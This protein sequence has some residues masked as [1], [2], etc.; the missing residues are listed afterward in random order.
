MD[1]LLRGDHAVAR[2]SVR[3]QTRARG[4]L[5]PVPRRKRTRPPAAKRALPEPKE[6]GRRL[7]SRLPSRVQSPARAP[8]TACGAL[9]SR[10]VLQPLVGFGVAAGE[11]AGAAVD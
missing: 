1:V 4:A 8:T 9:R 7:E 10:D 11:G 5:F 6:D 2:P 3:G